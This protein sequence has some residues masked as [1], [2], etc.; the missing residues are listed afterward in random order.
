MPPRA[1]KISKKQQDS[2]K[3]YQIALR[4]SYKVRKALED[5]A[6]R[7]GRGL[8]AEAEDESS[9]VFES[10]SGKSFPAFRGISGLF[11]GSCLRR[12]W[13]LFALAITNC[14]FAPREK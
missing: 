7:S 1:Q 9:G 5:A 13:P 3:R 2:G 11:L 8:A 14:F 10:T 12:D 6:E 4:V